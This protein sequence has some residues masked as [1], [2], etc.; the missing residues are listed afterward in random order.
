MSKIKIICTLGPSSFKKDI[1]N[2]LKKNKV[3]LL[4]INLSHTK[5]EEI[6]KRINFLKKNKVK[7][8]CIDTEG[9]QI[10]TS[11]IKKEVFYKKNKKIKILCGQKKI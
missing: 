2:Q 6:Q 4:R 11:Y 7:N 8:I 9:A 3:N 5:T 1:I 10:R